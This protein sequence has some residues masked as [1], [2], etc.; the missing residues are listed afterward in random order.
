MRLSA[1]PALLW[2]AASSFAAAQV[3]DVKTILQRVQEAYAGLKEYQLTV[4]GGDPGPGDGAGQM[5]SKL[6]IEHPDKFR[7]ELPMNVF[8]SQGEP[9]GS[10]LIVGSGKVVWEYSSGLNRYGRVTSTVSKEAA[11]WIGNPATWV[12]EGEKAILGAAQSMLTAETPSSPVTEERIAVGGHDMNC[13]VLQIGG[14]RFW[15]DKATYLVVEALEPTGEAT[16]FLF[17]H[18]NAPLR[19]DLF[20]LSPPPGAQ[21]QDVNVTRNPWH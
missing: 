13:L 7:W 9:I 5:V 1:L 18:V 15:V 16:K 19:E 12:T 3:P 20:V 10:V 14:G 17:E 2:I 21:H 4:F 11:D 8:A 6:T